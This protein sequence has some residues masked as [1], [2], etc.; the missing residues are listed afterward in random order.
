MLLT[1]ELPVGSNHSRSQSAL[2]FLHLEACE[3]DHHSPLFGVSCYL[4]ANASGVWTSSIIP[5]AKANAQ[6]PSIKIFLLALVC[7]GVQWFVVM[8]LVARTWICK[9]RN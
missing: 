3:F 9:I 1:F 6:P 8:F 7:T 2:A 4:L 5:P